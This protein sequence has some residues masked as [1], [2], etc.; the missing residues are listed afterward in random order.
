[1]HYIPPRY[2]LLSIVSPIAESD[3]SISVYCF[4]DIRVRL[5]VADKQVICYTGDPGLTPQ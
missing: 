3:I 5:L 4:N 1:M 2:L